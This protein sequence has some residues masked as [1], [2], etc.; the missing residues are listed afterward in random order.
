M[1]HLKTV[2]RLLISITIGMHIAACSKTVHWEEQVLLNT[3][4]TIW[5]ERTV[6]YSRRDGAGNPLDVAY[7]PEK[8][9]AIKRS[10]FSGVEIPLRT[11]ERLG[12]WFLRL[13][14]TDS[15]H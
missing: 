7:R 14:L 1:H 13:R 2:L 3:G 4:Q 9:Q 8:D 12:L 5:V 10:S 11:E 6:I 15:Q